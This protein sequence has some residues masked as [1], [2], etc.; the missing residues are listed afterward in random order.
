MLL[1]LAGQSAADFR[2]FRRLGQKPPLDGKETCGGTEERKRQVRNHLTIEVHLAFSFIA[3]L[4]A[5]LLMYKL[6]EG[7]K[8]LLTFLAAGIFVVAV[9]ETKYFKKAVLIGLTF[10]YFFAYMAVEPY[11]YQVPFAEQDRQAQVEQWRDVFAETIELNR[12][13]APGFENVVIWVFNDTT[14]DGTENTAWQIL[15]GLPEGTGISCC[16]PDYVTAN[17]DTLQSRYLV[18]VSGGE[19]DEMCREAGYEELGRDDDAVL[20]RRY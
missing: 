3:M 17:L 2:K 19:I 13:D 1:V 12:E 10:A 9:M 4:F 15:Y 8:H 20:Y 16:M 11:D 7:S 6:T 14:G 18:T 5:L